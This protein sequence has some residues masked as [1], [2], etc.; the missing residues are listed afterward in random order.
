MIKEFFTELDNKWTLQTS[1]SILL[2]II[3]STALFLQ[4]DYSRGTK[5]TD[6]LELENLTPTIQKELLRLSGKESTLYKKYRI[7]LEIIGHAWPFLPPKPLFHPIDSLNKSL[8]NFRIE[9]LDVVDVIVSKLKTFRL[10]D[11]DDI[12]AMIDL[13]LVSHEKLIERFKIAMSRWELDARAEDLPEYIRNLNEVERDFL[14]VKESEFEL[15][16]WIGD[17]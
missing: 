6:I 4:F 15:P 14:H 9:A 8:K 16:R 17:V 7:Y 11:Q 2:R 1:E 3:G 5:D 13:D 12:L 10:Q